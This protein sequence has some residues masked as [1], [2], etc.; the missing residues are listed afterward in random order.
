MSLSFSNALGIHESALKVRSSRAAVLANNLANIDTP[1]FKAQDIDFKG[2]LRGQVQMNKQRMDMAT[3]HGGHRA[4]SSMVSTGDELYRIPQQPSIDGNTVEEHVEHA[5][6]MENAM[7]FQAS[8]TILNGRFK[9]LQTA[10]R[11]E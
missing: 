1:N 11:G 9:G 4:G 10:I 6:Y 5:Q 3:T 2:A 7:A 8:F